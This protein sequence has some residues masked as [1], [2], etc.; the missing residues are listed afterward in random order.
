YKN[1]VSSPIIK[2]GIIAI[3]IGLVT[4]HIAIGTGVGFQNKI[5]DK[6]SSFEGH[7]RVSA[8]ES[9]ATNATLEGIDSQL[10]TSNVETKDIAFINPVAYAST[11]FKTDEHFTG[12]LLKG[13]DSTYHWNAFEDYLTDG[14]LPV[15]GTTTSREILV[16]KHIAKKLGV[17]TGDRISSFFLFEDRLPIRRSFVVS[18]LYSSGFPDFDQRIA[19]ADLRHIQKIYQWESYLVGALEITLTDFDNIETLSE[20]VYDQV[21]APYDLQNVKERYPEIFNWISLF[22]TNIALI[23]IIMII[24]GGI[25]MITALL[26]LILERTQMIGLLGVLGMQQWSTQ[27]VFLYNAGYLIGIGLFWG[28]L[29][30]LGLLFLQ[31]QTDWITLDPTSYYVT[32]VPIAFD[33]PMIAAINIGTFVICL[34]MLLIPSFIIS[35]VTPIRALRRV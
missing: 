16:S 32:T 17:N 23:V 25:N 4:M 35:K 29:L 34:L 26:V 10:I 24:V 31:H 7:L 12:G 28:N 1:S 9:N 18:G 2:I 5:K 6:I 21:P 30:G 15:I 13:I 22:D 14:R 19:F 33:V 27:K 3:T 11:V 8:Y 20:S